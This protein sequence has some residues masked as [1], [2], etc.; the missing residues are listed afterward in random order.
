MISALVLDDE[1][2]VLHLTKIFLEESG[3][4]RCVCVSSVPEAFEKLRAEPFDIVV[5][6]YQLGATD[7]MSVIRT[8]RTYAPD[9]P[10]IIFSGRGEEVITAACAGGRV[11]HLQKGMDLDEQFG[12]LIGLIRQAVC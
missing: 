12:R 8:I 11:Y 10:V 5:C 9:L 2:A 1:P 6:D 7:G 4:I 3:D